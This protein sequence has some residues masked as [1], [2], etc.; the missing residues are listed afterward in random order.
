MRTIRVETRLA[1][2][3]EAVWRALTDPEALAEWLMP[4]DFHPEPGHEFTF[5]SEPRPGFD[6][7][8][9]CRVLEVSPPERLAYSW[10]G[11]GIDT[12][13]T[14]TLAA[15]GSGTRLVLT[16]E[17]F[18][19]PGDVVARLALGFGWPSLLRRKLRDVVASRMAV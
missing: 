2:P 4:N 13:V 16:Q 11:G 1:F 17:G 10:A 14:F 6:G 12:V 5:R 9:R 18:R 19:F 15:E 7:V 8:V 3:R